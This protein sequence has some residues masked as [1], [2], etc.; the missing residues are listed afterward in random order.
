[1]LTRWNIHVTAR[2][3]ASHIWEALSTLQS[4]HTPTLGFRGA[5]ALE[6]FSQMC[7]SRRSTSA[8]IDR[9]AFGSKNC[10]NY[11]YRIGPS[12]LT[13]YSTLAFAKHL[14]CLQRTRCQYSIILQ[15]SRH[16]VV[17]RRIRCQ[18]LDISQYSNFSQY[19]NNFRHSSH[20]SQLL[21]HLAISRR[22]R[23]QYLNIS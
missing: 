15:C 3:C 11:D 8:R 5:F 6:Q 22:I 16:L 18:Y 23:C 13:F 10:F 9:C 4:R 21:W 2:R 1:M 20:Q 12:T 7:K 19:L 17:L 14:D